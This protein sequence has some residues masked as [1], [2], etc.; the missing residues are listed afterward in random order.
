V[1]YDGRFTFARLRYPIYGRS[2]W[3]FDYPA[4]ERHLMTMINEVTA[5]HPHMRGSN[6][7]DMDDPELLKYPV[8]STRAAR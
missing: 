2:G 4:M 3:E 1:P 5:L 7:H 6:V 8:A